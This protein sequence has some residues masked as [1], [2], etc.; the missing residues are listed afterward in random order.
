MI[1]W[2]GSSLHDTRARTFPAF[3]DYTSGQLPAEQKEN[4]GFHIL[5]RQCGSLVIYCNLCDMT[6]PS[7]TL[8]GMSTA[9]TY[10]QPPWQYAC[11]RY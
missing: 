5:P 6:I 11:T 10:S 1:D 8:R 3:C 4:A 9:L 2:I 7:N